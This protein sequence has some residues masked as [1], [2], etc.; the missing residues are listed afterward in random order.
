MEYTEFSRQIEDKLNL[1]E[2]D[3]LRMERAILEINDHTGLGKE[4]IL[5][6]ISYGAT[7]ELKQLEVDFRWSE[8]RNKIIK[9]LRP[10]EK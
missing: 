10:A 1:S 6:F 7:T 2:K 4:D 5:E 9:K 3:S 8:F